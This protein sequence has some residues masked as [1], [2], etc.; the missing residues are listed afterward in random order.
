M[1][2]T[3]SWNRTP[4]SNATIPKPLGDGGHQSRAHG[5]GRWGEHESCAHGV[6]TR[7][8]PL[9]SLLLPA[10]FS[11]LPGFLQPLAAWLPYCLSPVATASLAVRASPLSCLCPW[12]PP[13]MQTR[14]SHAAPPLCLPPLMPSRPTPVA[15]APLTSLCSTCF[16]SL[17]LAVHALRLSV[18]ALRLRL[19]ARCACRALGLAVHA[20]RL[21]VHA[22]RLLTA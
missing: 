9:V 4:K 3:C 7:D 10:V 8:V 6:G 21:A 18:H 13:L 16:D 17:V 22:L 14:A 15:A 11:C 2:A 20:L 1:Y 5:V 19:R 12:L